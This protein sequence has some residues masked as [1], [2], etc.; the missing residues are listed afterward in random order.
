MRTLKIH[1][2]QKTQRIL[3]PIFLAV[4]MAIIAAISLP[5]QP[6]ASRSLVQRVDLF[7]PPGWQI[8]GSAKQFGKENLWE[9]INGRASFF[10]AYDMVRMT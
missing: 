4:A 10:L 8:F 6:G 9:Q 2:A 3:R 5:G 1:A 7:T